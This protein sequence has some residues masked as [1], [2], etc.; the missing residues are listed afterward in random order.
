MTFAWYLLSYL[1][2][3]DFTKNAKMKN[4]LTLKHLRPW[5]EFATMSTNDVILFLTEWPCFCDAN[6]L[7]IS[8]EYSDTVTP[9]DWMPP[10]DVIFHVA[11]NLFTFEWSVNRS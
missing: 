3:F 8:L 2:W 10:N 9:S 11:T 7:E 4:Y 1:V 5:I 6:V